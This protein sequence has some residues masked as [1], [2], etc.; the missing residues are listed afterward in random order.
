MQQLKDT[1]RIYV[2]RARGLD[3]QIVREY[4]VFLAIVAALAAAT[5]AA[6]SDRVPSTVSNLAGLL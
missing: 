2:A 6:L 3:G 1:W 4:G 5:L